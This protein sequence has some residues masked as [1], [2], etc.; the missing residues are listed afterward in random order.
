MDET[1]GRRLDGFAGFGFL[2]HMTNNDVARLRW[3]YANICISYVVFGASLALVVYHCPL[4]KKGI[5][6]HSREV[7]IPVLSPKAKGTKQRRVEG[8]VCLDHWRWDIMSLLDRNRET[9]EYPV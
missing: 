1:P 4:F 6:C 9:Y 2:I 5:S 3:M 7:D 8:P